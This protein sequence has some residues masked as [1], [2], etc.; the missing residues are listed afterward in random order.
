MVLLLFLKTRLKLYSVQR[1]IFFS[2]GRR[3]NQWR[4]SRATVKKY[5][6]TFSLC[7]W[8]TLVTL[9]KSCKLIGWI[10]NLSYTIYLS[11]YEY[12]KWLKQMA[13]KIP[14][15]TLNWNSLNQEHHGGFELLVETSLWSFWQNKFHIMVVN[16]EEGIEKIIALSHAIKQ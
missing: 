12:V 3:V 7:D 9:A 10:P 5:D 14:N 13:K 15:V 4:H 1:N 2:H 6:A 8:L 11:K 16:V